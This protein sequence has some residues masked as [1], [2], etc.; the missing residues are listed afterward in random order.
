MSKGIKSP[1]DVRYFRKFE[2]GSGAEA[3]ISYRGYVFACNHLG[4]PSLTLI[5]P[6]SGTRTG[7]KIAVEVC[8]K[9]YAELIAA[10]CDAAWLEKNAAMYEGMKS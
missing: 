2:D 8:R 9:A 10:N 3:L 4:K 6:V 7:N 1:A 5:K